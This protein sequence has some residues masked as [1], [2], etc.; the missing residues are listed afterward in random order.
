MLIRTIFKAFPWSLLVLISPISCSRQACCLRNGVSEECAQNLCDPHRP[1]GDVARYSLFDGRHNCSSHLT[2]ISQCLT[3]GRD[4]LQCCEQNA[5]DPEERSCFGLCSG[6]ISLFEP[7]RDLMSCLALNLPPIY[8]CILKGYKTIPSPPIKLKI[9]SGMLRW[10]RPKNNSHLVTL[11][12]IY[13]SDN[14]RSRTVE[15][16]RETTSANTRFNL[17]NLRLGSHYSVYVIAESLS[18]RS[19]ASE[20]LNMGGLL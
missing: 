17:T 7:F 15:L 9:E 3:D 5:K 4:N 14:S 10:D 6:E 18:G 8:D 16:I 20:Q 13:I 1:P 2:E 12:K 19:Q 11:Y